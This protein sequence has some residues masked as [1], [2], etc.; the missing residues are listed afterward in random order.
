MTKQ[1]SMFD[2]LKAEMES[3][4]RL[5]FLPSLRGLLQLALDDFVEGKLTQEQ[6]DELQVIAQEGMK[7]AINKFPWYVRIGIHV[8]MI[9]AE[10]KAQFFT[11]EE[12]DE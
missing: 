8:L 3:A 5:G 9:G 7:Y 1:H 10:I 4:A 12:I 2:W 11:E 6:I